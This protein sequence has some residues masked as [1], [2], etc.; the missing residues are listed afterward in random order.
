MQLQRLELPANSN[1]QR[2]A[3]PGLAKALCRIFFR[4][5]CV[6][7]RFGRS[8]AVDAV[9]EE[10]QFRQYEKAVI[11][12]GN[13]RGRSGWNG[14]LRADKEAGDA[15]EGGASRCAFRSSRLGLALSR[16]AVHAANYVR[17][18]R[19]RVDGLS[20]CAEARKENTHRGGKK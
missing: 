15:G 13:R 18:S 9:R 16:R 8:A 12:L 3:T 5:S 6:Q 17:F 7:D 10:F 11:E 2:L 1:R 4:L 20:R 19:L 14:W